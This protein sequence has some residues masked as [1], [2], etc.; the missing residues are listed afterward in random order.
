MAKFDKDL[1]NNRSFDVFEHTELIHSPVYHTSLLYW[2]CILPEKEI[3][4]SEI[5]QILE[6]LE[7]YP[8]GPVKI[9]RGRTAIHAAAGYG[10]YRI[11]NLL[12]NDIQMRKKS[13]LS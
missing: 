1:I 11:L 4:I 7:A 2:A 5:K 10:D 6:N 12:I 8:E 13:V 3:C 9:E